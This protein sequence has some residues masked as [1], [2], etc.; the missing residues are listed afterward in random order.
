MRFSLD[1]LPA[2]KGDCLILHY[3]SEADPHLMIIDGGPA[4]VY[5]PQLKD[6]LETMHRARQLDEM[7]PLPIDVVLVSHID[8]DHIKGIIELSEEQRSKSPD[9]RLSV[10]S[11]WHNSFTDILGAEPEKAGK[12]SVTA[13]ILAGMNTDTDFKHVDPYDVVDA[14][15]EEEAKSKRED[16]QQSIDILASINQGRILRDNAREL[17]WLP[18]HKFKGEHIA[19]SKS[20]KPVLLDGL[21]ITVVGPMQPDLDELQTA[22][23]KWVREHREELQ[24]NPAAM[25]AAFADK[26]VPNLS[27]IVLFVEATEGK[28]GSKSMLL[29]GDARGDEILKGLEL[30]KV[31]AEG[32]QREIDI[33]KVPHHGS[34][35]NME[36]SFFKRLPARHYVFSGN[37]KHGNPAR[38]TF[39]MLRKARGADAEYT[40]HLTYQIDEID[41]NREEFW[42]GERVKERNRLASRKAS[43]KTS[44]KKAA[45]KTSRKTGKKKSE[46]KLRAAWSKAEH[47]LAAFFEKHPKMKSRISFVMSR[48]PHLINLLDNVSL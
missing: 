36:T 1:V 40:I 13:S 41:K 29:T 14:E 3:G 44:A 30:T 6:R 12:H 26:S 11:L 37:G 28:G 47:S 35:N 39:E 38:K 43:A 31:V 21:K 27:S 20:R 17:H 23:A 10:T 7:D 24:K 18:N 33:L 25:L 8:D 45:K 15:D 42:E 19:A 4:D 22:H 32:G 16:V 46:K 34:E 5:R 48:T 9:I 2:H